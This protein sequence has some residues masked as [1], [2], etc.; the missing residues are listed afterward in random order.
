[1]IVLF[2]CANPDYYQ[3]AF[4]HFITQHLNPLHHIEF[5]HASTVKSTRTAELFSFFWNPELIMNCNSLQCLYPYD[6]L[7]ETYLQVSLFLDREEMR[8][9]DPTLTRVFH[10][11]PIV[12]QI[13]LSIFLR[14]NFENLTGKIDPKKY[15]IVQE[16]TAS[17]IDFF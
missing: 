12:A 8:T 9:D 15:I 4:T 7:Y 3:D 2:N 10:T 14:T 1:M 11:N 17:E 6:T 13:L 16:R 5:Y